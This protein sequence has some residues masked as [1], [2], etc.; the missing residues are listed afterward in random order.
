MSLIE[1]TLVFKAIRWFKVVVDIKARCEGTKEL[2]IENTVSKR[3][4]DGRAP[5]L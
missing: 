5:R 2:A 3:A 1:K 4:V